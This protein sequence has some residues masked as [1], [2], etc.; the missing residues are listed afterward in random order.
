[1]S[2]VIAICNQKGGVGKTTTAVNLGAY[3]ANMGRK[4]LLVDFD[5]Q[6]NA[7]S[8]LGYMNDGRETV[9]H[10]ILSDID[11]F[12]VLRASPI[13]NYHYVP[14]SP[15]LAGAM[16]ELV[17]LPEREYYLKKFIDNF[18]DLYDYIFIDLAPSMSLLT[19]NGLLAA[20]EILIPVQAEYYSLEGLSQLIETV[21]MVREYAGHDLKVSGAVI[22][23]F[24]RWEQL[25]QEV[26]KN[27]RSNFPY[28]V[29]KTEIP[30]SV[31]LAEAPSFNQP[32]SLYAPSSSGA[33]AYRAL[34]E[35]VISQE[36]VDN[37][38]EFEPEFEKYEQP[39]TES[40]L[41]EDRQSA[42]ESEF[43]GYSAPYPN[44]QTES[45]FDEF[46]DNKNKF[47]E[48]PLLNASP[49][50]SI[51]DTPLMSDPFIRENYSETPRPE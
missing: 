12:S 21:E 14:A 30:R 17:P 47:K 25:S 35:E 7:S 11:A 44:A 4:V 46:N 51:C 8:A 26:A 6:A 23:M 16:V 43:T 37:T 41:E 9:Y 10:G 13:A 39:I 29:F 49:E 27:L 22:T 1:M 38:S 36:L 31:H 34:A 32:I 3:L 20:D 24:D 15:H 28:L 33:S 40:E 2:R 18:R 48:D 45:E 42:P 19:V 5:P 50:I